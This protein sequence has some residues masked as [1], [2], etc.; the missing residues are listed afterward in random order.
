MRLGDG[1]ALRLAA[2][3][4]AYCPPETEHDVTNIGESDLRYVYLV[5]LAARYGGQQREAAQ[6]GDAPDGTSRRR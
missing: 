4:L 5:A 1:S 6:P 3:C 2:P